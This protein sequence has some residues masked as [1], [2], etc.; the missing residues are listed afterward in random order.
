[1]WPDIA[2]LGEHARHASDQAL[3]AY[4]TA[5]AHAAEATGAER[6]AERRACASRNSV[7]T[8][9][10]GRSCRADIRRLRSG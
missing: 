6:G 3:H 1:M 7:P 10:P 5:A 2:A 4:C 8:R 9:G